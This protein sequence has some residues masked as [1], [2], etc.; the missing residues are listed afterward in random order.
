M[1]LPTPLHSWRLTPQEARTLQA[2]LAQRVQIEPLKGRPRRIAGLDAA[3]SR[4]GTRMVGAVVLWDLDTGSVLEEAVAWSPLAFPYVPG[5]L[6]FREAPALLA[7]LGRLRLSPDLLLCDGQG[8]AHPRKFGL[9]C[10][11]G[12]LCD[13]PSVGCAKSRLVGDATDPGSQKGSFTPLIHEGHI[14]GAA[15]RTR[16]G[17]KPIFV[18]AGHKCDLASAI[19]LVLACSYTHRLP[20]PTHRA[21]RLAHKARMGMLGRYNG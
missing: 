13:L 5:L 12:L 15:L 6:S 7:A 8:L 2:T 17:A 19:E 4:D 21:D 3:L 14:V 1:K 9:A 11:L 18:S 10:H 16:T 20:E